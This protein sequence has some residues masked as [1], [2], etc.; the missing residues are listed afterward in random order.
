M[1]WNLKDSD[2]SQFVDYVIQYL[3]KDTR[4]TSQFKSFE[5]FMGQS[6]PKAIFAKKLKSF[7]VLNVGTELKGKK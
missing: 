1:L 5:S 2:I 6:E 7:P 4:R 3:R